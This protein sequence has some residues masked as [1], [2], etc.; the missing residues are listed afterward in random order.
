[1]WREVGQAVV[2]SGRQHSSRWEGFVDELAVAP[3]VAVAFFLMLVLPHCCSALPVQNF[4]T[5]DATSHWLLGVQLIALYCV[6]AVAY[7]YR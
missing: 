6:I 1:M 5:A 2:T 4:V 3:C 7:F